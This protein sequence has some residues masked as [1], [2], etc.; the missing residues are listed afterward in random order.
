MS[1]QDLGRRRQWHPTP[2]PL[3]GKSHGWRSLEGCSPWDPKKSES[4]T[5]EQ[6]HFDFSLSCIGEGNGDPLQCS[7]LENPRDG[8]AWWAAVYGVAQSRTR[9]KRLSSSSR[10]WAVLCPSLPKSHQAP[11][12]VSVER[13]PGW[14]RPP[15][16]G[17]GY[18]LQYS[19]LENLRDRGT[20]WATVQR[21]TK[22][23][24]RLKRLRTAHHC[25]SLHLPQS[26]HL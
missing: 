26:P 24:K 23:W 15:G 17:D 1:P 3:P 25:P 13:I 9:L 21:V 10:T 12:V 7:C 22:S 2:V 6:L 19:C 18:P 4:D 8:G 14:G 5:T 20:W 16:E 11:Q